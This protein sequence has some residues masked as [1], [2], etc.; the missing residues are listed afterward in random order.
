MIPD[1]KI[2]QVSQ[3][4]ADLSHLT[5]NSQIPHGH[6]QSWDLGLVVHQNQMHVT[7]VTHTNTVGYLMVSGGCCILVFLRRLID[8]YNW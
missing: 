3:S 8:E 1:F 4:I 2:E 6:L 7:Q 5:A